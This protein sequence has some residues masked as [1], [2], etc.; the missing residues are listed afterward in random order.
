MKNSQTYRGLPFWCWNGRLEKEE[1]LR[2][3]AV[4]KQMGFGGFFIHSR[5]GLE[6]EYLGEEW[7]A[8]VRAVAEEAAKLGMT[9]WLYDED[10]WPSGSAGGEVTKN[11]AFRLKFISV[12]GDGQ[13]PLDAE[14][15]TGELGRFA[16]LFDG[17][18]QM[19]DYY[20]LQAGE[21]PKEGYTA[22]KFLIETMK[23]SPFYNGYTY[24]DTTDPAATQA[25]LAATHEK[26]REKCGDLF[27]TKLLGIFTDEPHRG[28][29]LNGFALANAN[30]LHM[31]PYSAGLYGKY[32]SL[33]G[34]ELGARLPEL[35]YRF[36]GKSAGRTMYR[37]IESM[38]QLF[39][40]NFARP[41][42]DWCRKNKLVFTG[43]VLHEDSLAMQT[44]FQGSVQRFYEYM[45]Y[46]GID[47]L[48]EGNRAYWVAKQAQSVAR[49][50]KKP[51]VLSELYGCTGWQFNF[52]SHRDVGAWQALL[53]VNVR[54]HHLC[55]YT[56][57]GEAKRDYPASIFYQSGWY[58]DYKYIEDYFYRL[59]GALSAGSSVCRVLVVNPVES[60]WLYPRDGWE[61]DVFDL[62]TEEGRALEQK[63]EQLFG[64]LTGGL[65]DFD[66]GDEDILSRC[67]GVVCRKGKTALK[68]GEAEYDCV[69]V[70]GMDTVRSSTLRLLSAFLTSGGKVLLAGEAPAFVD[71]E[72]SDAAKELLRGCGVPFGREAILQALSEFRFCE[73]DS[74]CLLASVRKRKNGF[75]LICLNTDRE[76]AQENVKF[77]FRDCFDLSETRPEDGSRRQLSV[78]VRETSLTFRE[79]ECRILHLRAPAGKPL[80]PAPQGAESEQVLQGE[81]RYS[82]SERNVLPLDMATYTLDG[83]GDGKVREILRIDRE[84]RGRLGMPLR[85]GEMIQ[86]WYRKKYGIE[87]RSAEG[88]KLDL[89][90]RFTVKSLPKTACSLAIEQSECWELSLNGRPLPKKIVGHWI[91]RCF[92]ELEIPRGYLKEGENILK[93]CADFTQELNTESLYLLG[94]FG[95]YFKNEHT[96]IDFLPKM[97]QTGDV[98]GQGLPFYSGK[99]VYATGIRDRLL[100]VTLDGCCGAVSCVKGGAHREYVAFP[101]YET[102]RFF[103]RGE[104]K[105]EVICTRRNTFGPLHYAP[106]TAWAYGP[107]L[108]VTE[109]GYT[110]R[111]CLLPQGISD[112]VLI[113]FFKDI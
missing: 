23:G 71:A 74:S 21:T 30:S 54:N 22:E 102:K 91:D 60:M 58:K 20:P 13:Q 6:T 78:G 14:C 9:A 1:L 65:V 52:R 73:A 51:H 33:W 50:F 46:P 107:D 47:I 41:Y 77:R 49:Q 45:D 93:I 42:R 53:G 79:G 66:Y 96:Y 106:K 82:L 101:P 62:Q 88:H 94:D 110:D 29:L 70:A 35:F 11:P 32:R 80:P 10:R 68:V 111:Y 92:D 97:L 95:V 31:L 83:E 90:F 7:F 89:T 25:F 2:Q 109:E 98:C 38:Q 18:G 56:M 55:W 105:I 5:T 15:I 72:R 86:P 8:L 48:T 75:D 64:I 76:H 108:F 67:G 17:Q 112:R 59:N 40:E 84:V 104:L 4:L 37:Y 100:S 28:A 12:Y 69:V 87:E 99:I 39:L 81:M 3:L 43:H 16:I 24:L 61:K 36:A 63:Y 85:G 26:Y 34:E 27:G 44:L 113:R 57:E 103:C 19:L